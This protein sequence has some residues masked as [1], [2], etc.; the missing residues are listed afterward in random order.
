MKIVI[1]ITIHLLE[2]NQIVQ[3][4]TKVKIV[5]YQI[6]KMKKAKEY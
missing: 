1:F 6:M 5:V 2:E 4:V 3:K